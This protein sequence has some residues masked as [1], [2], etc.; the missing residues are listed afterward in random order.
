M[1]YFNLET[2]KIEELGSTFIMHRAPSSIISVS[3][4]GGELVPYEL[5][6]QRIMNL[7]NLEVVNGLRKDG[8]IAANEIYKF[9]EF[10]YLA[11]LLH[12]NIFNLNRPR[13]GC[14]IDKAS[15]GTNLLKRQYFS[16][17]KEMFVRMF[18]DPFHS[19]LNEMIKSIDG[20][21]FLLNGHSMESKIPKERQD[22]EE[23]IKRP[24]FGFMT[25]DGL[26][27]ERKIVNTFMEYIADNAGQF[28]DLPKDMDIIVED[29]PYSIVPGGISELYG[30]SD[31]STD[32]GLLE[33]NKLLYMN[34]ETFEVDI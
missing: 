18:Y 7:E 15:D 5:L 32:S 20:R 31:E 8:D 34:E 10:N 22:Y 2:R 28:F 23:G 25:T 4:H 16:S 12:R 11:S 3:P 17:E 29:K 27:V 1:R 30:M 24:A 26:L 19:A 9:S 33:I 6:E 21:V 14:I 13:D